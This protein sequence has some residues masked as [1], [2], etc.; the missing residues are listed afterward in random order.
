MHPSDA[1]RQLTKSLVD[2]LASLNIHVVDHIIVGG[3]KFTSFAEEGI[4]PTSE[5]FRENTEK[6]ASENK[7][8]FEGESKDALFFRRQNKELD[9]D[10]EKVLNILSSMSF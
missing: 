6:Y 2:A 8:S 10:M 9:F 4:M 5:K 3:D 7:A 1:D